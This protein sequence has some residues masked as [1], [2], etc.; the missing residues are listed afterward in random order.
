MAER[1]G[2][3]PTVPL[4]GR[5]FSR[6]VHSTALPP[7]LFGSRWL[8][9]NPR[10]DSTA[11]R[12]ELYP[13]FA[14]GWGLRA[15][16]LLGGPCD[17]GGS[18]RRY[19]AKNAK[20]RTSMLTRGV[21]PGGALGSTKAV[22]GTRQH[23]IAVERCIVEM[24]LRTLAHFSKIVERGLD[25]I[26]AGVTTRWE[27]KRGH[28]RADL[29]TVDECM[30]LGIADKGKSTR[31]ERT[32]PTT[33]SMGSKHPM[34]SSKMGRVE[35]RAYTGRNAASTGIRTARIA[36]NNPP[37]KPTTQPHARP[38]TTRPAPMRR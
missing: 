36:G 5:R 24:E 16:P 6:P 26:G 29:S 17:P 23:D 4:R 7:L 10:V 8:S 14:R 19:W 9:T 31:A 21:V 20:A 38:D 13:L 12:I 22:C 28:Q 37:T 35:G 15:P 34:E 18:A 32:F 33:Y 25:G 3:E 27:G 11:S 1:V 2:F 30:L